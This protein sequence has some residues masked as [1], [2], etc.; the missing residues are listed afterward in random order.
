MKLGERDARKK[1]SI[2]SWGGK[3]VLEEVSS[4]Q[5]WLVTSESW[6]PLVFR[7]SLLGSQKRAGREETREVSSTRT[8]EDYEA[9]ERGCKIKAFHLCRRG[10]EICVGG[11]L[12][13]SKVC[14]TTEQHQRFFPIQ[15]K[16]CMMGNCFSWLVTSESWVP[17]VFRKSLLGSQKRAGREETREVSSTRTTEDYEAEERGCKIKAFHLCR[18]GKEICVGGSLFVSKVCDT[19]EQHQRFF[20]I[21]KKYCMMGNCFSWLV[22]SESWVPL[23]FRKSLLGSQKRAGREE[24]REVSS[25]R[26]TE[27]YEAEERGCKI[28]AFHLCRRGKEICV[29]GSLFVSKVCDTTEQHQRFFPI[30]KYCMMGN[31]FR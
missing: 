8:T 21:Q 25:T 22:T 29:G 31:C 6:V 13:V 2:Y 14:D 19:T 9:E 15:K 4:C 7:K 18:R 17:L 12:F 24:T 23:V 3:S 11:S 28:K 27:D 5:N 10:K 30:Q 1:H 20:P 26:T 16:Y